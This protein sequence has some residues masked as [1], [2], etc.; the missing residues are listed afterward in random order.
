MAGLDPAIQ[1]LGL[2]D[3]DPTPARKPPVAPPIALGIAVLAAASLAPGT[4]LLDAICGCC[5]CW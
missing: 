1:T 4:M 5:R 2:C 3:M